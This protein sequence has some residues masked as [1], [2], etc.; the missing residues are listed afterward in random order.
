MVERLEP[1]ALMA[2]IVVDGVLDASFGDNGVATFAPGTRLI[3]LPDGRFATGLRSGGLPVAVFDADLKPV[4]AFGEGGIAAGDDALESRTQAVAVQADGKFVAL[5]SDTWPGLDLVLARYNPD[6]S[7]DVT[8]DG[9]GI[10]ATDLPGFR[11]NTFTPQTLV[12]RPDGGIIVA[13]SYFVLG[14]PNESPR[15]SINDGFFV[16]V[17]P[18]GV[19]QRDARWSTWPDADDVHSVALPDGSVVVGGSVGDSMSPG[20]DDFQFARIAPDGSVTTFEAD[21]VKARR[22]KPEG[23]RIPSMSNPQVGLEGLAAQPDGKCLAVGWAWD[24]TG[25]ETYHA[26]VLRFNPDGTRDRT[27]A[28]RGL[29]ALS[30]RLGRSEGYD[31]GVLP[32]GG[33]VVGVQ[34]GA[35]L[36]SALMRLTSRGKPDRTFGVRGTSTTFGGQVPTITDLILRGEDEYIVIG[37]ASWATMDL[38]A[39]RYIVR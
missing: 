5:G 37:T 13:G 12:V 36:H 22:F 15:S 1:R 39:A 33:I 10:L 32:D 7:R 26:V 20:H 18:D 16:E 2:S 8:F 23:A 21:V 9:D 30:P 19:V 25:P 14:P 11:D 28:R 27:F 17:S 4:A 3:S 34:L 6:G 24:G 38:R 29:F 31:V 35:P